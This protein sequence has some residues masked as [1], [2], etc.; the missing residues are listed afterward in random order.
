MPMYFKVFT[1]KFERKQFNWALLLLVITLFSCDRVENP[2]PRPPSD[3]DGLYPGEGEYPMPEFGPFQTNHLRVLVEDFTGHKC[4]FC[5]GAGVK[6]DQM[7]AQYPDIIVPVAIH[8][9]PTGST[10]QT[11]DEAFP[12][13][14]R[15]PAGNTYAQQLDIF[16]NPMGTFN[17]I[18][19]P[20]ADFGQIGQF[21]V[22]WDAAFEVARNR[23]LRANIQI[24]TNYYPETRGLMVHVQSQFIEEMQ[25]EFGMIIYLLESG[26]ISPQKVYPQVNHPLYPQG[27]DI[28]DYE[29][30]HVLI[31]NINGTLG[32]LLVSG[33]TN[34]SE[35]YRHDYAYELPTTVNDENI[36]VVAYLYNLDTFE[37]YQVDEVKVTHSQVIE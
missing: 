32:D 1:M 36:Y 12:R 24:I 31:D 4:G 6:L 28:Q 21:L 19:Y 34:T 23:P 20:D 33:S 11:V 13:E 29:H 10:F 2:F 15:T 26:I 17:R 35:V 8:A 3:F 5:P 22:F 7:H 9:G 37:I 30:N 25:G 27:G 14:F 18:I 16:A